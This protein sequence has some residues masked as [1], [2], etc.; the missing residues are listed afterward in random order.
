M[1]KLVLCAVVFVMLV[2][3]V[4]FS[5]ADNLYCPG[6]DDFP[7]DLGADGQGCY[8]ESGSYSCCS[9]YIC[10]EGNNCHCRDAEV[11][12]WTCTPADGV[13]TTTT[14][15]DS[16]NCIAYS[17]DCTRCLDCGDHHCYGKDSHSCGYCE[18]TGNCVIG[19]STGP[20][21][22][23]CSG[24]NW[25][26]NYNECPSSPPPSVC[27]SGD[28]EGLVSGNECDS[29]GDGNLDGECDDSC[30]CINKCNEVSDQTCGV[31]IFTGCGYCKGTKGVPPSCR[32]GTSSG[33]YYDPNSDCGQWVWIYSNCP[34]DEPSPPS[35]VCG[36]GDCEGKSPGDTCYIASGGATVVTGEC[37]SQCQCEY[38]S[39]GGDL[40]SGIKE[41]DQCVVKCKN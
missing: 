35:S 17:N 21:D 29:D 16:Y 36:P 37:N 38:P 18:D 28:C 10:M 6:D 31:C 23:S 24:P 2:F 26:W 25:A 5:I 4:H 9:N 30:Q 15:P 41:C 8:G 22:G 33:P 27:G 13:T 12:G 14:V 11:S 32:S 40:C 20:D 3:F 39:S 7:E 1:K 34:S 19:Y